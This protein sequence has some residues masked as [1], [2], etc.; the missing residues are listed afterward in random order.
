MSSKSWA[1]VAK[2]P[3]GIKL[4]ARKFTKNLITFK[5]LIHGYAHESINTQTPDEILELI[6]IYAWNISQ[7]SMSCIAGTHFIASIINEYFN[8][9]CNKCKYAS[10][11]D[12]NDNISL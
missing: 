11:N 9:E 8:A 12:L 4:L 7:R 1:T 2:K 5:S 3:L 10:D 6:R